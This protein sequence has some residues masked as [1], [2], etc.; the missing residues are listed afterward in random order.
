MH[1]QVNL[2][3]FPLGDDDLNC[4]I[5]FFKHYFYL[6]E[7]NQG[8]WVEFIGP[9]GNTNCSSHNSSVLWENQKYSQQES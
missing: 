3:K 5:A 7:V 8:N 1:C 4:V 6:H 9:F 2:L